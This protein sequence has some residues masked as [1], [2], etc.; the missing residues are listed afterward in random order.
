MATPYNNE[1][2]SPGKLCGL[3]TG[4]VLVTNA[5]YWSIGVLYHYQYP[6]LPNDD[7]LRVMTMCIG[8]FIFGIALA[9]FLEN[10]ADD[11]PLFAGMAS[12]ITLVWLVPLT[13]VVNTSW[14][15]GLACLA[16]ALLL[17]ASWLMKA[18]L[19]LTWWYFPLMAVF[20]ALPAVGS[21]L[22]MS[23]VGVTFLLAHGI[24]GNDKVAIVMCQ[25]LILGISVAIPFLIAEHFGK[26]ERITA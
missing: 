10:R 6:N 20:F 25:L 15:V 22:L 17:G 5:L 8:A 19:H 1:T 7:V 23:R 26:R 4:V 3:M 21:W 16:T 9:G 12:Y 11:L 2:Q 13:T 24:H 18:H 14:S